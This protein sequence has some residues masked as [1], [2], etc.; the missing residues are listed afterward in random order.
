VDKQAGGE[1]TIQNLREA[2]PG[3]F[4]HRPCGSRYLL[5]QR[6]NLLRCVAFPL[7]VEARRAISKYGSLDPSMAMTEEIFE[8]RLHWQRWWTALSQ[9]FLHPAYRGHLAQGLRD[10]ALLLKRWEDNAISSDRLFAGPGLQVH[11]WSKVSRAVVLPQ[12]PGPDGV[13]TTSLAAI[14]AD[15]LWV[16]SGIWEAKDT[17]PQDSGGY[18]TPVGDNRLPPLMVDDFAFRAKAFKA[19]TATPDGWHP[20]HFGRLVRPAVERVLRLLHD[21]EAARRLPP[22]CCEAI[23]RRYQNHGGTSGL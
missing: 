10:F 20:W 22:S 14:L 8:W 19:K 4:L 2:G 17:P 13:L 7:L 15:T 9:V 21:C 5:W 12:V 23:I 11:A 1:T 18:L 16:W 6:R 3:T